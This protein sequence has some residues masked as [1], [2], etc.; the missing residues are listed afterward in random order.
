MNFPS[1]TWWA[2]AVAALV[3]VALTW[4]AARAWGPRNEPFEEYS[5]GDADTDADSN[6]GMPDGDEDAEG[7]DDGA[8]DGVVNYGDDLPEPEEPTPTPTPGGK[9]YA[10]TN[11]GM[12]PRKL[13][14][15][16]RTHYYQLPKGAAIGT[17]VI[18]PGCARAATGF[19]PYAPGT[20]PEC[21]GFPEDVS[22]TKQALAR[23]YAVLVLTPQDT[24]TLC[25][26]SKRDLKDALEIVEHFLAANALM[27]KPLYTLGASSGGGLALALGGYA[28]YAKSRVRV[29]GIVQEVATTQSPRVDT[30]TGKFPP[31]VW[32]VM[33]RFPD[34]RRA[35]NVHVA[36]LKRHGVPAAVVGSPI[37]RITPNYFSD[38]I[39]AITPAQ[40]RQIGVALKR[41]G[42]IDADG[43]LLSDPKKSGW[44]LKLRKLLPMMSPTSKTLSLVFR[45][46]AVWQAMTLAYSKHEHTGDYTGAALAWFEGG[47]KQ[48]FAQLV[49]RYRVRTPAALTI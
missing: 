24:K 2:W 8:D 25:W 22:Q 11:A 7:S 44:D 17:L 30:H 43:N 26:S 16:G 41:I 46:S 4:L 10:H 15:M 35:A 19:W 20:C 42:Q 5:A 45:K 32:V 48:D 28:Q 1:I 34:E 49:E 36:L 3:V 27:S 40:S 33:E 13:Q 37:R 39:P 18:F 21:T 31:V 23:G 38:R 14:L 47:G 9:G 12:R 29:S 6:A